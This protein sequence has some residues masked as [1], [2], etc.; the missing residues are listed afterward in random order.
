V[1]IV[2]A[3]SE[4]K[5]ENISANQSFSLACVLLGISLARHRTTAPRALHSTRVSQFSHY[6][7]L[8]VK[9]FDSVRLYQKF[10]ALL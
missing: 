6:D 8:V 9:S 3:D 4:Q 1:A 10:Y 5:E 7:Q 2:S